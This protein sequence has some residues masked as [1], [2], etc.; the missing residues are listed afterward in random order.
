MRESCGA[1]RR[2]LQDLRSGV[3]D[4]FRRSGESTV[5]INLPTSTRTVTQE[6]NSISVSYEYNGAVAHRKSKA[7]VKT[8]E[9]T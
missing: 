6:S 8:Q 7:C 2:A 5:H 4:L 3:G 1:E 9:S